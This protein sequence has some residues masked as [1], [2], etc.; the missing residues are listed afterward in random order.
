MFKN[1]IEIDIHA[2]ILYVYS[3]T[4]HMIGSGL[5]IWHDHGKGRIEVVEAFSQNGRSAFKILTG[6][7]KEKK[8]TYRKI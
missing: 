1:I 5:I 8:N 4:S 2:L 3:V 7:H 6:K